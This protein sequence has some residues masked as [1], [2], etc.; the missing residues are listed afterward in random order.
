MPFRVNE[1]V[2]INRASVCSL[3]NSAKSFESVRKMAVDILL[4]GQRSVVPA[5]TSTV[6]SSKSNGKKAATLSAKETPTSII[7]VPATLTAP[8]TLFNVKQFLEHGVFISMA[9]LQKRGALGPK[10]SSIS[11]ERKNAKTGE[12]TIYQVIDSIDRLKDEEWKQVV[13]VFVSGQHWQFKGW[14]WEQPVDLFEN[15]TFS[16]DAHLENNMYLT[17]VKGYYVKYTD[18]QVESAVRG[19]NVSVL[20]VHRYKRHLDTQCAH[21]FWNTLDQWISCKTSSSQQ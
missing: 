19:W 16:H 2:L 7:I 11:V 4:R 14:K 13:A 15:S 5:P 20:E 1:R 9:E 3:A 12:I 6:G 18:S 8:V 10:Q 17:L 21:K